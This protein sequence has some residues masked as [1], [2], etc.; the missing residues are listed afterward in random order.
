MNGFVLAGGRSTRMG[1]DKALVPYHG[2]PL[3][4][5]AVTLL[6]S[7]GLEP[8][9]VG[10]RPDLAQYAP[11]LSDVHQGCGPL[12]GIEAA[13]DVSSSEWSLFLAVDLPLMPPAF[14]R[15]LRKRVSITEAS[16]T[17]PTFAGRPMPLCAVYH[18]K[19]LAGIRNALQA[20]EYK[21]VRA[22]ERAADGNLDLFSVEAVVSARDDLSAL[23]PHHWF[24]NV[25][26]PSDLA[27]IS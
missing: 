22:I 7:A 27:L 13:L 9:I 23:P 11:V 3:I 16:A 26:T 10:T 24:Q 14:L 25:N 12:G 2:R 15:Y 4:E 21:V 18:R 8:H 17:V 20:S 5:H 1:R 6:R 19:L